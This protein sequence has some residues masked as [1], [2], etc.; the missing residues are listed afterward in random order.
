MPMP[1]APVLRP[2]LSGTRRLMCNGLYARRPR[3]FPITSDKFMPATVTVYTT[4]RLHSDRNSQLK[5]ARMYDADISRVISVTPVYSC[6]IFNIWRAY[7][8]LWSN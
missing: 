8:D 1:Y 2:I 5:L 6:V 4:L 3:Y 7:H